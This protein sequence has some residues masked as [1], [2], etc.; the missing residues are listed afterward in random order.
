MG[1]KREKGRRERGRGRRGRGEGGE[2]KGEGERGR[3]KGGGESTV[4]NVH[5]RTAEI[6]FELF[7]VE[8]RSFCLNFG[9]FLLVVGLFG[10]FF[11][12]FFALGKGKR[13][14]RGR[15]KKRKEKKRKEKK[16]KEK[17]RKEKKRKETASGSLYCSNS[18]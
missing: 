12:H 16:R 4:G 14:R 15:N 17:K 11:D 5:I 18:G 1:S 3:G 6:I 2:G 9:L 7:A 13:E 8:D 10:I